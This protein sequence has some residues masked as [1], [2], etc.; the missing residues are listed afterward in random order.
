MKRAENHLQ[1]SVAEFLD[2]KSEDGMKECIKELAGVT[3]SIDQYDD[4]FVSVIIVDTFGEWDK[5]FQERNSLELA[6]NYANE[7]LKN[8]VDYSF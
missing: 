1:F 6:V 4:D 2:I 3:A 8:E 7:I 5:L